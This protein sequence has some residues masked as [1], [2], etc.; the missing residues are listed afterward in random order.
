MEFEQLGQNVL[1]D[2]NVNFAIAMTFYCKIC[3]WIAHGL[4]FMEHQRF[5]RETKCKN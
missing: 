4:V 2:R 3:V 5:T 1:F